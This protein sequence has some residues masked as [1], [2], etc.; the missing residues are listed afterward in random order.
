MLVL[1]GLLDRAGLS[2]RGWAAAAVVVVGA[3]TAPAVVLTAGAVAG[4]AAAR[5]AAP[6]VVL[7]PL[8]LFVA[9][10]GDAVFMALGA[11][12]VALLA[13]ALHHRRASVGAAAGAV[14]ALAL[15][16]TYGL[17]PLLACLGAVVVWRAA[18]AAKPVV[19]VLVAAGLGGAAVVALWTAAGF[20]WLDGLRATHHFYGLR[21]GNDRPYGY[22]LLAD[23]AVFA[24]MLGPAGIA[25]LLHVRRSAVAA[26][27]IAALVAVA[28]AD[29]SGLSKAEVERI[30]LPFMPWVLLA[31]ATLPARRTR[32]WLTAQVGLAIG[33]QLTIA[34][35]W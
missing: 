34:W 32:A 9:T 28:L 10:T 14:G 3:S 24:L 22:F 27:V 15:Y 31:T 12:A 6:F 1:Y 18:A 11:W 25:A 5:R 19:A 13:L 8:A 26:L 16:F 23:L 29:L 20:W 35:P 4:E 2:G 17:V 7:A 21:A 30:W 33:L